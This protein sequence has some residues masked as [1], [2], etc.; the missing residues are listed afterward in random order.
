M[1]QHELYSYVY[2][3]TSQLMEDLEIFNSVRTII[4]FGSVVRG[5]FHKKSDIDLFIDVNK[6]INNTSNRI[7]EKLNLFETKSKKTWVLRGIDLPL[8][9]IVDDLNNEKW[10]SLREEL[11]SYG[12]LIYGKYEQTSSK[13]TRYFLLTFELKLLPQREKMAIV[14]NLYGYTSKKGDKIYSQKKLLHQTQGIKISANT[15][16]IPP[17]KFPEIKRLLVEYN[18]KYIIK[19]VW[20]K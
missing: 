9:V 18:V 16:L 19:E 14:R 3:F 12:K 7:K 8:K 1:K 13:L 10:D 6:H 2:D 11:G 4:L 17:E 5:D 15:I 20:M